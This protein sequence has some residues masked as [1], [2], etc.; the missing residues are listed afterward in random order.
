MEKKLRFGDIVINGWASESN[1]LKK[2]MV[3]KKANR[4]YHTITL[5]GKHEARY[6]IDKSLKLDKIGNVFEDNAKLKEDVEFSERVKDDLAGQIAD[7][8][9]KYEPENAQD[10]FQFLKELKSLID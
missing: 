2:S 5:D 4:H 7:L 8:L 1:P 10:M 3:I 9:L 6:E